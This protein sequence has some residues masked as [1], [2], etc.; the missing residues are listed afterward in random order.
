MSTETGAAEPSVATSAEPYTALRGENYVN[1]GDELRELCD[2]TSS[3]SVADSLADSSVGSS[4]ASSADSCAE[5]TSE[6]S[7]ENPTN[8]L[9]T[10][11]LELH[12]MILGSLEPVDL[13]SAI[14]AWDVWHNLMQDHTKTIMKGVMSL[15]IDPDTEK[16]FVLAF[17]AQRLWSLEPNKRRYRVEC[18]DMFQEF[19][20][21]N[22]GS[23]RDL[24][25]EGTP[26]MELL[27]FCWH[28]EYFMLGF[29]KRAMEQL[30]GVDWKWKVSGRGNTHFGRTPFERIRLQRA[31][32]RYE[33]INCFMQTYQSGIPNRT[34]A[35]AKFISRLEVWEVEELICVA[36]Y[37]TWLM[38]ET[39][40]NV[41]DNFVKLF[42][43]KK[44]RLILPGPVFPAPGANTST[45]NIYEN[46]MT[47]FRNVKLPLFTAFRNRFETY[48]I[49]MNRYLTTRGVLAMWKLVHSQPSAITEILQEA[50]LDEKWVYNLPQL[51]TTV[52]RRNNPLAAG[53]P[54]PGLETYVQETVKGVNFGWLWAFGP[55]LT[56]PEPNQMSNYT[57]RNIGYVFWDKC[58]LI[59][60]P[61]AQS[62]RPV[63]DP[64]R[65]SPPLQL[66]TRS[67][68]APESVF[69]RIFHIPVSESFLRHCVEELGFTGNYSGNTKWIHFRP[70]LDD[71]T[72][73][74]WAAGIL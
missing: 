34:T 57:L 70:L 42:K 23:L 59:Q 12:L 35:V 74:S 32:F 50:H 68:H 14:N 27:N 60:Y 38:Q 51:L 18:Q 43:E 37:Y 26:P 41:D 44:K 16:E 10:L 7:T 52:Y 29:T 49:K 67:Y 46:W 4:A 13:F 20:E 54:V 11:P 9:L 33:I 53:I 63:F 40:D 25:S 17:R 64:E 71:P 61:F 73:L 65:D 22:T 8:L 1:A 58:R 6:N 5:T 21:G 66:Q 55:T 47:V 30:P 56:I 15:A 45:T 24:I 36:Q 31:F 69:E 2:N 28:F 48:T 39:L 62:P 19:E 3:M 72:L